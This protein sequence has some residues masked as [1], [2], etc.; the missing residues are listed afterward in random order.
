VG[1]KP[2]SPRAPLGNDLGCTAAAAAA[3][4]AKSRASGGRQVE[5]GEAVSANERATQFG[6][7]MHFIID[8]HCFQSS[9]SRP[10]TTSTLIVH[11]PLPP[12]YLYLSIS[13]ALFSYV[14]LTSAM[15]VSLRLVLTSPRSF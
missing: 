4:A 1:S 7:T 5:R 9:Q 8:V 10:A 12:A 11:A 13:R 6:G 14:R 15:F 2:R 3:E